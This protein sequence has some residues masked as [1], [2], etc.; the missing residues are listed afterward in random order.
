MTVQSDYSPA[1]RDAIDTITRE[2]RGLGWYP[3]REYLC[4]CR[5]KRLCPVHSER[6]A[7][8]HYHPETIR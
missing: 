3:A 6:R 4:G 2:L 8:D 7:V 5:P 1:E